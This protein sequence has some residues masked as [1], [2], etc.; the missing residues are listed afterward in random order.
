MKKVMIIIM[1]CITFIG[2]KVKATTIYANDNINEEIANELIQQAINNEDSFYNERYVILQ[3]QNET[4]LIVV[5]KENY[6]IQ[7]NQ[8]NIIEG[9][10]YKANETNGVVN[11]TKQTVTNIEIV[12]NKIIETNIKIENSKSNM[13]YE[14]YRDRKNI[15]GISMIGLGIILAIMLLKE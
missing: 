3:N 6:T 8:I 13:I 4:T 7:T 10:E 9:T 11:Y 2:V 12:N 1:L 14:S 15:I 5:K